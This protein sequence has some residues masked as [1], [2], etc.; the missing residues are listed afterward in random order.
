MAT[1]TQSQIRHPLDALAES[2]IE[3]AVALVRAENRLSMRARFTLVWL[4]EP[5]KDVVRGF[6]ERDSVPREVLMTV[7]DKE[8]G[9][10][11]RIRVSL[12]DDEILSWDEVPGVQPPVFGEEWDQAEAAAKADSRFIEGCKKRGIDDLTHVFVDPVSAGNFGFP[13][14][15]GRRL[16]AWSD[17]AAAGEATSLV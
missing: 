7:L 6:A 9:R 12:S 14:E 4:S 8:V 16:V 13:D 5:D 15:V 1:R 2:E 17:T 10:V 3:R 11:Y